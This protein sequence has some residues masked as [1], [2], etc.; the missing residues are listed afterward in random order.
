MSTTTRPEPGFS[1]VETIVATA[2]LATAVV[3][4]AQLFGVAVRRNVASRQTTHATILAAQKIEE[5]RAL[6]W[7]DL[8]TDTAAP[9][10]TPDGGTGLSVSPD[11]VLQG[12]TAGWVDY[13]DQFGRKLGGGRTPLR[14]AVYI[15]RWA[16]Q[17]LPADPDNTLIIQVLVTQRGTSGTVSD[18]TG[19]RLPE[20]AR[21]VTAR[22]SRAQ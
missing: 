6:T 13:V 15:R 20:Q 19:P 14:N 12:N 16:V 10:E 3:T 21:L 1:L 5:L 22:T 18:S 4:L 17:P 8:T 2:L 11:G 7:G 9:V